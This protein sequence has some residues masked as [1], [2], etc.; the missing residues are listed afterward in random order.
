MA[1]VL[2]TR[3]RKGV[4]HVGDTVHGIV[5]FTNYTLFTVPAGCEAIVRKLMLYNAQ[6]TYQGVAVGCFSGG[7]GLLMLPYF[8]LNAATG[9][10]FTEDELPC[11]SWHDNMFCTT[12]VF[13][14]A[15][16]MRTLG[17]TTDFYGQAEVEVQ[18][19]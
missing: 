19:V 14:N 12:G 8:Y 13:T 9:R 3:L 5:A 1:T 6:G 7:A 15:I 17:G 10:T 16:T 11:L 18:A 2:A 4:R